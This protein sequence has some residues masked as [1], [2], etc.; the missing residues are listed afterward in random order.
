MY[1]P[2]LTEL[3]ATRTKPDG[4]CLIWTGAIAKNG[5][6]MVGNKGAHRIVYEAVH[7][8]VLDR[9]QHVHHACEVRPCVNPA[10]LELLTINEHMTEHRTINGT[11]C[12]RGHEFT[13]ENT[14]QV[15]GGR[16]CRACRNMNARVAERKPERMAKANDARRRLYWSKRGMTAPPDGNLKA[17]ERNGRALLNA[18]AAAAIKSRRLSGETLAQLAAEYGV[19]KTTVSKIATGKLWASTLDT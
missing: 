17:G 18:T 7:G 5:Y 10:H 15:P 11:H 1:S 14:K 12:K 9:R 4:D 13:P 19:S 16:A 6:G 3:L 8:V 2:K